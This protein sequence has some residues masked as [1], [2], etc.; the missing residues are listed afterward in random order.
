MCERLQRT[1]AHG[2]KGRPLGVGETPLRG[3]GL[4]TGVRPGRSDLQAGP[5]AAHSGRRRHCMGGSSSPLE[6]S[7]LL[8]KPLSWLDRPAP[9]PQQM[10]QVDLLCLSVT[11]LLITSTK[12][13]H[14]NTEISIPLKTCNGLTKWAH[15]AAHRSP[16]L[17]SMAPRHTSLS[18]ASLPSNKVIQAHRLE[19]QPASF[20]GRGWE[21]PGDAHPSPGDPITWEEGS[22]QALPAPVPGP[23]LVLELVPPHLPRGP[24]CLPS[25]LPAAGIPPTRWPWP[26]TWQGPILPSWWV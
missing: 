1:G 2:S 6:A 20:P 13:L 24:P 15:K 4:H 14:S 11:V 12:Y 16:P 19:P 26:F 22:T 10:T 23:G 8:L 17:A 25:P 5:G 7:V 9:R 18:H 3:V 21:A